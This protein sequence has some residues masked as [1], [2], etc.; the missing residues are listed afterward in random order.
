MLKWFSANGR[1]DLVINAGIAGSYKEEIKIGD[2]VM[3]VTDCFADAGIED[4]N[5]FLTLTE[6][7]L[8][9]PGEFPFSR[10]SHLFR[11]RVRRAVAIHNEGRKCNNCQYGHRK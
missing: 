9:S 5:N 10:G 8:L 6:A 4:G 3:P 7:G 11:E 2:V 1:P